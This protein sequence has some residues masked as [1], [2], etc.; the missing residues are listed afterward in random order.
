MRDD[1]GYS[2]SE[3]ELIFDN[4]VVPA[5]M[6]SIGSG[7]DPYN[8]AVV[9]FFAFFGLFFVPFGLIAIGIAIYRIGK[10]RTHA[11]R[12]LVV[13]ILATLVGVAVLVTAIA[14]AA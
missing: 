4:A 12:G 10:H 8:N 13:A 3:Q 6:G 5:P 11:V 7:M 14:A 9:Y 2:D 1:G